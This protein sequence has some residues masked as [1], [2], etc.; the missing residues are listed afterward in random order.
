MFSLIRVEG[1][2]EK[3]ILSFD[4]YNSEGSLVYRKRI[5]ESELKN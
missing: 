3:R 5:H 1:A 2:A 4:S